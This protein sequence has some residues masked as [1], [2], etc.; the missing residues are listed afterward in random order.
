A[1]APRERSEILRR[2]YDL[3][4]ERSEQLAA[5]MTA[6]MG[7]PLAE[8]RGEVA[9]GAEFLRWFSEEAVRIGGDFTSTGDGKSRILVTKVPVGPCVLITPWNFPLAMGTRKIGPAVAAGCTMVFKPAAQTPLTSLALA[10]IFEEAGLPPGV[11]NVVTTSTSSKV[12]GAWMSSGIARKLSFTGSTEVGKLLLQQAAEHVM[13]TSME[14]GG[15]A[16]FI[17]CAD[18]NVDT[19]VDGAMQAKL[20]NMGE[21]CTAANRFLVHRSVAAEFTEKLAA[22]MAKLTVGD[23]SVDGTDVGPLVDAAGLEKV[24][25]LVDDAVARGACVVVGGTRPD[26]PG[27]FY[28]PTVLADVSPASDLMSTE[29]FGPVAPVV[30]FDDDEDALRIANDTEWGLVGYVFTQD[31][32]RAF[33]LGEALEVGMV[34]INSGLVSNPAAPFGGIKQSGLG[35]EGGRVG[36]DEFLEL[37]YLAVP[38]R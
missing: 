35:R 3:V 28:S 6:E 12:V 19:A 13:R 33:R 16:P 10:G 29:I 36:I 17:V 24:Q 14:L 32:D 11:L 38:R 1:T 37:K 9:Y 31:I 7:K 26:G 20:R 18:A 4:I 25:S 27:H 34:G 23:G 5:I 8:A 30:P 2:A 21:A 15:N 22:R